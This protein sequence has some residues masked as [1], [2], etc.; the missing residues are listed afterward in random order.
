MH[1]LQVKYVSEQNRGDLCEICSHAFKISSQNK[2]DFLLHNKGMEVKQRWLID[3]L[4]QQGSCAKIA[5]IDNNPVAQIQFCPEE[6]IPYINKPRKNVVSIICIYSPIPEAQRKGA[7]S[8]L[9]KSL[10]DE[11]Y[12]GLDSLNGKPCSLL[13]TL[14]FPRLEIQLLTE[15]YEKCGFKQGRGEMF[16]NIT[17]EYKAK[18]TNTFHPLPRD[19]DRTIILYNAACEWGYYYAYKVEEI[20]QRID[21]DHIIEK[22]NIWEQPESYKTRFVQRVTAGQAIVKGQVLSGGIF[23]TDREAFHREVLEALRK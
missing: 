14:P 15:F 22:Y 18:E 13:V 1:S 23:W 21:P 17:G 7:A 3:R 8:A 9:V 12:S 16:I 11:C 6:M 5:Y 4:E 19:H 2:V 20:I 10:V